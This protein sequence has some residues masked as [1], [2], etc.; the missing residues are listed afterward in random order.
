MVLPNDANNHSGKP[1]EDRSSPTIANWH[2]RRIFNK[3]LVEKTYASHEG[4]LQQLQNRHGEQAGNEEGYLEP[5]WRSCIAGVTSTRGPEPDPVKNPM[6]IGCP[7]GVHGTISSQSVCAEDIACVINAICQLW[8]W[9]R[10]G[11]VSAFHDEQPPT[12]VAFLSA[13]N[14]LNWLGFRNTIHDRPA[15]VKCK[16]VDDAFHWSIKTREG[17]KMLATYHRKW[18]MNILLTKKKFWKVPLIKTLNLYSLR[19]EVFL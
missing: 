7:S 1:V 6:R 10:N 15:N 16:W 2:A 18:H 8:S 3:V 9:L 11:R 19:M 5:L 12:T 17:I 14:H 13:T 4:M